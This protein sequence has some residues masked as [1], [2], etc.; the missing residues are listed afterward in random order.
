[1]NPHGSGQRKV[2]MCVYYAGFFMALGLIAQEEY[3]DN[4]KFRLWWIPLAAL[5]WFSVGVLLMRQFQ[6]MNK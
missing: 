1:M 5:S 3:D 6:R 4:C 2:K